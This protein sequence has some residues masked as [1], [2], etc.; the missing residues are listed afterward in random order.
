MQ[1]TYKRRFSLIIEQ[2]L[3]FTSKINLVREVKIL[4]LNFKQ[5]VEQNFVIKC[6]NL[7][8]LIQF[9]CSL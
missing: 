9:I 4:P 1:K 2:I 5:I 6:S 3:A 8:R 7:D